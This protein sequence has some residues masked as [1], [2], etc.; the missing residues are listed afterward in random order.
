MRLGLVEQVE[1]LQQPLVLLVVL[2]PQVPNIP[3]PAGY[4]DQIMRDISSSEAGLATLTG[5][6]VYASLA[7]SYRGRDR[8]DAAGGF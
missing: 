5:E 4:P 2:L 3:P 6:S 1:P 7:G 8:R